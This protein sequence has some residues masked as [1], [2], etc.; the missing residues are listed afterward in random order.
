MGSGAEAW[1]L[2]GLMSH[3]SGEGEIVVICLVLMTRAMAYKEAVKILLHDLR[4]S[5]LTAKKYRSQEGIY[6][7]Q[8]R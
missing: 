3:L 1:H 8:K 6:S 5:P 4:E 2:L 7:A